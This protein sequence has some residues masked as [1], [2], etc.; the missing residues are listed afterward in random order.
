MG[1]NAAWLA[2]RTEWTTRT[3]PFGSLGAFTT[4]TIPAAGV[5]PLS[6]RLVGRLR[7]LGFQFV[8]ICWQR[9][10]IELDAREAL[11]LA[12]AKL[13]GFQMKQKGRD[14]SK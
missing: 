6:H 10:R 2:M 1:T 5:M 12:A 13:P 8:K 11:D 3:I 7:Q 9:N 14:P 4:R